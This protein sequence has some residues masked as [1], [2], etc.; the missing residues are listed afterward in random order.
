MSKVFNKVDRDFINT[1]I[2]RLYSE[3]IIKPSVSFWRVQSAIVKNAESN[4]RHMCIDYSQSINLFTELDAYPL[5][6]IDALVNN[7]S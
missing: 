3:G 5:P 4:E 6:K 1:E 2:S 7:L